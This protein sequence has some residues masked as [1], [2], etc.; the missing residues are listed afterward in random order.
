M[1]KFFVTAAKV[2]K[3]ILKPKIILAIFTVTEGIIV[4]RKI[5]SLISSPEVKS[6]VHVAKKTFA[7]IVYPLKGS[8]KI[9]S[10]IFSIGSYTL[11]RNL[12]ARNRDVLPA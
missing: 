5:V 2:S 8:L 10:S 6:I 12:S 3:F 7:V 1:A 9:L 11:Y 4:K